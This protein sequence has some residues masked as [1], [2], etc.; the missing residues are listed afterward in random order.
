M[1]CVRQY[2][3]GVRVKYPPTT[4]NDL[5]GEL[6]QL[7]KLLRLCIFVYKECTF[8]TGAIHLQ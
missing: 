8:R 2:K 7:V 5:L 3:L 4:K 1:T 6:N